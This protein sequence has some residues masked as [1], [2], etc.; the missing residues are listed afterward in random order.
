VLFTHE[1]AIAGI[2][3]Q[4]YENHWH[5]ASTL[6]RIQAARNV[7][8]ML[9]LMN[10]WNIRYFIAQKP[11][12]NEMADP[13]ALAELLSACTLPEFEIGNYYLARLDPGCGAQHITEPAIVVRP[14]YYDDYDPAIVYQGAWSKG[15]A[16][17][18]DHD[19]STHTAEAGAAVS[20]AFDGKRIY[21]VYAKGPD[22]GI[23]SV[24]IDGVARKLIDM[25]APSVEWQHKEG[26]CCF[27]PGRHVIVI[28]STAEKNPASSG[29][30]LDVDSFSVVE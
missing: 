21:Y 20:L 1:A 22:H 3:A 27:A 18:P 10:G 7:P 30:A 12:P 6:D 4:I 5:Q 8:A 28:R 25:Y 19:T 23:A 17:G 14:G 24:T 29:H 2:D 26:Y 13:P 9:N 11:L 15:P 16:H